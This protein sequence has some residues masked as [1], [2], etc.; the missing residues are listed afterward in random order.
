MAERRMSLFQPAPYEL[1]HFDLT[2]RMAAEQ[3]FRLSNV[4]IMP[5]G[6]DSQGRQKLRMATPEELVE[7]AFA[8]ATLLVKAARD[9]G[10]VHTAVEDATAEPTT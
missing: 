8:C 7:K 10:H 2:G 6:E 4:P 3:M 9:R 1:E 5:D